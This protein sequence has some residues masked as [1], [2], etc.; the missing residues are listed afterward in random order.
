MPVT[1]YNLYSRILHWLI[2][3]LILFMIFLG[4]RLDAHDSLR[5]SRVNLHKSVGIL[6]LALSFLRLGLRFIY[7][8]PPAVEGPKWEMFAAKSLHILFYVVM[9]G[10]PLSGWLMVST[11]AREIPFFGLFAV[12]HLPVPQT[13][14]VHDL[15]ETAHGLMAK[16]II[17]AMFPLHLAAALKHHVINKDRVMEHMVPGLTPRPLLNWRWI[18]PLGVI[19]AAIGFGYGVYQGVP[20]KGGADHDT[21]T[22]KAPAAAE[23]P[24]SASPGSASPG[25]ASPVSQPTQP[26]KV[27]ASAS[28]SPLATMAHETSEDETKVPTWVVDTSAT[29][30]G[31]TTTFSGEAVAGSFSSYSSI[32]AFDPQQLEKSHVKVTIDLASVSSGD[33]DRDSTLKSDSFFNTSV[34]PKAVYEANSF[35]RTDATHYVAKG[36]LT[37]HGTTRPLTMPFSLIIAKGADAKMS[38]HVDIDR[39]D[40]GVGSG[41]YASTSDIP[42]KVAVSITLSA[43]TTSPL[44]TD[45]SSAAKTSHAKGH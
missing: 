2:A 9:I 10:M 42:A 39:T 12:P 45:P 3:G 43:H 15:F 31:F 7:A 18:V 38:G 36:R 8:A 11:S 20:E 34:T 26:N 5:L 28:T 19:L 30:I 37:L 4:W 14:S 1:T 41:D 29:K 27:S 44:A 33:G 21:A 22:S 25:S 24:G 35:T 32:I 6:I 40:F 13:H 23:S 17:Y 16:L